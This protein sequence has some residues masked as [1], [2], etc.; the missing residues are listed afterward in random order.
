MLLAQFVDVR[1]RM[2]GGG[3]VDH[4]VA[5]VV[6]LDVV[7]LDRPLDVVQVLQPEVFEQVDLVGVAVHPVEHAVGEA[8]LH[9]PAVAAAR[10]AADLALV[11]EHDVA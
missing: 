11:D 7:A 1:R 6:A 10:R 3:D 4:A 8:R 5:L 9:E 2:A